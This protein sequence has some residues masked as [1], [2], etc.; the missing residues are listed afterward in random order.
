M[1]HH[2]QSQTIHP[3]YSI[4]ID[5]IQFFESIAIQH[6]DKHRDVLGGDL[7]NTDKHEH[8]KRDDDKNSHKLNLI[9]N[10]INIP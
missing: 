4:L 10:S 6:A 2:E 1:L 8:I 3:K 7:L 9:L 5:Q